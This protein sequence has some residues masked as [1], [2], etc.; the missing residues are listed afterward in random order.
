MN[1]DRRAATIGPAVS[2]RIDASGEFGFWKPPMAMWSIFIATAQASY[3]CPTI[4]GVAAFDPDAGAS[5][6]IFRAACAHRPR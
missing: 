1:V 5:A 2:T 3:A 6:S 4:A